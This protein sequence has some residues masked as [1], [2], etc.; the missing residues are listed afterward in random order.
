MDLTRTV[1]A[2]QNEL[3]ATCHC[4]TLRNNL[5]LLAA[6]YPRVH[7]TVSVITPEEERN[8]LM[9][10]HRKSESEDGRS[11]APLFLWYGAGG[12]FSCR[13]DGGRGTH[14]ELHVP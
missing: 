6:Y 10:R 7:V 9:P 12:I 2:G 1:S 4:P 5:S 11:D 8:I 3:H 13:S 14:R